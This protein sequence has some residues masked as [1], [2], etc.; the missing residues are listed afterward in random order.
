MGKRRRQADEDSGKADENASL[1]VEGVERVEA[2]LSLGV[3]EVE[4]DPDRLVIH[5]C[6]GGTVPRRSDTSA[7]PRVGLW[8]TKSV[9]VPW[10]PFGMNATTIT[11]PYCRARSHMTI[12]GKSYVRSLGRD[13]GNIYGGSRTEMYLWSAAFI[14]DACKM[15][16]TAVSMTSLTPSGTGSEQAIWDGMYDVHW[17]PKTAIGREFEYVPEHIASAASEAYACQ[18][19]GAHRGAAALARAVVEATAKDKGITSGV[20]HAKI[21]A[22]K[23]QDLI[24]PH[25]A[26]AAHEVRHLGNDVA[27]G[28][29]VEPVSEEEADEILTLMSEVLDEVFTSPARIA[30]VQ[31]ARLAKKAGDA[32]G[33][34]G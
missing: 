13:G 28:D 29:F 23:D 8:T 25:I 31:A 20:L 19:V 14:C 22:M 17:E 26:E 2:H 7:A 34:S 12:H 10:D 3:R 4:Q 24:R 21:E 30:A 32:T 9:G 6:H 11:C 5:G 15:M 33:G 18:S 1:A 27:H 16:C